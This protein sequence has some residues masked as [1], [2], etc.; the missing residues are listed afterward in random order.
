MR[1]CVSFSTIVLFL[2]LAA[3]FPD[4]LAVEAPYVFVDLGLGSQNYAVMNDA[5]SLGHTFIN[6]ADRS[7]YS[8]DGVTKSVEIPLIG[9]YDRSYATAINEADQ[10]VGWLYDVD[11]DQKAQFLWNPPSPGHPTG[12]TTILSGTGELGFEIAQDLSNDGTLVVGSMMIS[13]FGLSQAWVW[14]S[15]NG[16]RS[17]P[18]PAG[19]STITGSGQSAALLV[20]ESEDTGRGPVIYGWATDNFVKDHKVKWIPDNPPEIIS[21][22]VTSGTVGVPYH[23]DVDATDPDSDPLTFSLTASPPGMTINPTTGLISWI[24]SPDQTGNSEVVVEVSDSLG[25]TDTQRFTIGVN[26]SAGGQSVPVLPVAALPA[27]ILGIGMMA[28]KRRDK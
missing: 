5:N 20:D 27:A 13:I 11:G 9:V 4:V 24:P 1:Q 2:A 15:S 12:T 8:T 10:I 26:I 17:L 23:Y 25:A 22:P 6:D 28:R 18:I 21:T 14:D 16:F 19:W 3:T 7:Y